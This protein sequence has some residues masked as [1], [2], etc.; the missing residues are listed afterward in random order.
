[1]VT[2]IFWW[3]ENAHQYSRTQERNMVFK[4]G[5]KCLPYISPIRLNGQ[6]LN[7]VTTSKDL[8]HLVTDGFRDDAYIE[9]ELSFSDEN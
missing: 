5:S 7:R 8:G 6:Q 9:R 2:I 4:A 1:M 3:L